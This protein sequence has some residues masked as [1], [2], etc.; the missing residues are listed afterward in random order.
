MTRTQSDLTTDTPSP[1]AA[2]PGGS[3]R[4]DA[5]RPTAVT[6][7]EGEPRESTQHQASE[8]GLDT[9]SPNVRR[10]AAETPSGEESSLSAG[11]AR[12]PNEPD[13]GPSDGQ[14]A[15]GASAADPVA[16]LWGTDLVQ[17]YRDQWQQLQLRFVDDPQ[18]ATSDAAGLLDEAIRSLTTTLADQK[19]TLDTWQHSQGDDT[20]VLRNALTRYRDFLD[21]LLGL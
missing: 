11:Q 4:A 21:R 3:N 8:V 17:R 16:A 15:P 1:D 20:E 19:V 10:P 5:D 7:P 6:V 2:G 14:L 12:V 13:Q 18:S 9:P